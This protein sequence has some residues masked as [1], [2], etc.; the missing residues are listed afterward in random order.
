MA[1]TAA[2]IQ[3]RA[4]TLGVNVNIGSLAAAATANG[5]T[6]A[7]T[8]DAIL[9]QV[10]W[11]TLESGDL[12][13]MRDD[14]KAIGADYLVGVSEQTAQNYAA[15]IASGEMSME[16]VKSAMLKQ[17]LAF[18]ATGDKATAKLLLERVIERFPL[19]DEAGKAKEKLKQL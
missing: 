8:I 15:K 11:A 16:G 1:Q 9:Q 4:R 7:Q 12:T 13:A 2:T 10:N 17:A 14:V 6:D 3:N 5:W 18:E 19:S